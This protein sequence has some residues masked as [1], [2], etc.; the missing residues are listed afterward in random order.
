MD[1]LLDGCATGPAYL[2]MTRIAEVVEQGIRRG[3]G[4]EYLLHAWVIMPNHVH[5]LIT[6]RIEMREVMRR[7]KGRTAREA[8]LVL[9][10]TGV[11]FWQDESYDRV[12]KDGEEFRRVEGYILRNPVRAGLA[13]EVEEYRW[14][15][16]WAGRAG[17]KSRAG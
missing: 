7:M 11:A 1:R 3:E 12:V 14:S 8:N 16:A 9:G 17:L 5:L 4:V 10:R 2:K 6:P 13:R 15:S